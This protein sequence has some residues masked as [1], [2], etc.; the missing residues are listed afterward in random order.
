MIFW[1]LYACHTT[2]LYRLAAVLTQR[3]WDPQ[4]AAP[5]LK[6]MLLL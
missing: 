1:T 2:F 3:L 4:Q 5:S 6:E